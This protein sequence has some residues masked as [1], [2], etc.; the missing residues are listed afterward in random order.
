MVRVDVA[1]TRAC[2]NSTAASRD[3]T[4]SQKK[5]S[6]KSLQINKIMKGSWRRMPDVQAGESL[7]ASR[8]RQRL[9]TKKQ[10][11]G[12]L[13]C[14]ELRIRKQWLECSKKISCRK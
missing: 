1:A 14:F 8:A 7:D 5:D 2:S 4:L 12:F 13:K 9:L 3:A 6:K 11:A 10:S